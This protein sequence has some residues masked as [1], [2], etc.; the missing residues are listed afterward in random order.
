MRRLVVEKYLADAA[1]VLSEVL[2]VDDRGWKGPFTET[3][4]PGAI[5]WYELGELAVELHFDFR[6]HVVDLLLSRMVEGEFPPFH[7]YQ[8]RGHRCRA[9]AENFTS[10]ENVSDL[11]SLDRG[12]IRADGIFSSTVRMYAI[13]VSHNLENLSSDPTELF[14]RLK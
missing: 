2:L 12:G 10:L 6:S 7:R 13:F 11:S 3:F 5:L 9:F 14:L 1:K 8:L 4:W